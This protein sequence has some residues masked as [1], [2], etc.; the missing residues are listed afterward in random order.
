MQSRRSL[1]GAPLLLMFLATACPKSQ[2]TTVS[3]NPSLPIVFQIAELPRGMNDYAPGMAKRRIV[4][5]FIAERS[6]APK[7]GSVYLHVTFIADERQF[8]RVVDI[9]MPG[10]DL[11]AFVDHFQH[12]AHVRP[13]PI[14]DGDVDRILAG[15]RE[16]AEKLGVRP[17]RIERTGWRFK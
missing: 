4:D 17:P 1:K 11:V 12:G 14:L 8:Q 9:R 3:P 16:V 13:R 7:D 15:L 6:D 2:Q 10:T 5:A